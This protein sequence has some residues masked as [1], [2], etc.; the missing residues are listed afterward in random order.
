[1]P[2]DLSDIKTVLDTPVPSRPEDIKQL[3]SNGQNQAQKQGWE[4]V[5]HA[6]KKALDNYQAKD[7]VDYVEVG[8]LARKAVNA[9]TAS[10]GKLEPAEVGKGLVAGAMSAKTGSGSGSG[11]GSQS[12]SQSQS[13]SQVSLLETT[14]VGV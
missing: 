11:S 5:G 13:Q 9:Y 7:K 2:F 14:G 3:S 10:G 8:A 1:M 6:A 12:G 4:E